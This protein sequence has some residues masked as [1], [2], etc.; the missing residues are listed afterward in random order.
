MLHDSD[1]KGL[2]NNN[3]KLRKV[4]RKSFRADEIRRSEVS[5]GFGGSRG[6][7]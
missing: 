2:K 7:I 4:V 1:L 5:D 6:L 3:S